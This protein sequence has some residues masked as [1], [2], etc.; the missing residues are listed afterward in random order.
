MAWTVCVRR[1]MGM[2]NIGTPDRTG[3]NSMAQVTFAE[4]GLGEKEE[5]VGKKDSE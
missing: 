5:K 3:I 2:L 1:Q 4:Q